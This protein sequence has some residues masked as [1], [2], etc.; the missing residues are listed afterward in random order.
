MLT[1]DATNSNVTPKIYPAVNKPVKIKYTVI[2]NPMV[3][4]V[5]ANFNCF[6]RGGSFGLFIL[7]AKKKL[8]I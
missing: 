1:S 8:Y 6:D 5:Q 2:P 3:A 4:I 7:L